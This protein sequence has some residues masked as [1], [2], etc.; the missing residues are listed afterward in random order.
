MTALTPEQKAMGRR[1]FIK[2]AASLPAVGAFA[3][4]TAGLGPVKTGLVGAGNIGMT[5]LNVC[6]PAFADIVAVCDIRPSALKKGVGLARKRFGKHVTA[7]ADFQEFLDRSDLEAII[8]STP[9]WTH[10]DL[11][12]QAMEAGKH[13]FCEKMMAKTVDGCRRMIDTARARNKVLQIGYQRFYNPLYHQANMMIQDG[14]IGDVFHIR[15]TWGLYG[16]RRRA[17]DREDEKA[18]SDGTLNPTRY[19]YDNLDHLINWRMLWKY[20]EGYAAEL[21]S[22]QVSMVNWLYGSPPKSVHGTGG[23]YLH[24]DGREIQDHMYLTFEYPNGRVMTASNI[25]SNDF[26]NAGEVIMG[27][28]GTIILDGQYKCYLFWRNGYSPTGPK[29]LTEIAALTDGS[30]LRAGSSMTSSQAKALKAPVGEDP[31]QFDVRESYILQLK[32]FAH[33]IRTGAPTLCDGSMG[34]GAAAAI[35]AGNQAMITGQ[36]QSIELGENRI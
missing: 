15:S 27:T 31:G 12:V 13:V 24:Q 25:L 3:W 10:A 4:T 9:L 17:I 32:G 11:C 2:T 1:T 18:V 16:G 26:E 30:A 34:L 20:S 7:H 5:H 19:G 33:S 36:K 14:F 23:T 35:I 28:N 8:I 29:N 22:H 21:I 6:D